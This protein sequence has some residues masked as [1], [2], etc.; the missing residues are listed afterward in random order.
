MVLLDTLKVSA[1]S[2]LQFYMFN[3]NID[4]FFLC[5]R[6]L[7]QGITLIGARAHDGVAGVHLDSSKKPS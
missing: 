1:V 4:L 2:S 3:L 7:I 5:F 6:T